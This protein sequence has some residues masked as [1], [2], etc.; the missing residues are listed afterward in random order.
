MTIPSV[1]LDLPESENPHLEIVTTDLDAVTGDW[2]E[3]LPIIRQSELEGINSRTRLWAIKQKRTGIK[4][5]KPVLYGTPLQNL[6]F[7][8]YS[9]FPDFVSVGN[10]LLDYARLFQQFDRVEMTFFLYK[11]RIPGENGNWLCDKQLIVRG[12]KYVLR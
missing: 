9:A 3:V 8:V 4:V 11:Q 10:V 5:T 12:K 7:W 6:K 2:Y 1:F